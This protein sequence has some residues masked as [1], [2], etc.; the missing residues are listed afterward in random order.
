MTAGSLLDSALQSVTARDRAPRGFPLFA[1]VSTALLALFLL[2]QLGDD[3]ACGNQP[4]I[5]L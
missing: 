4:L 5:N 2:A 3:A 1:E